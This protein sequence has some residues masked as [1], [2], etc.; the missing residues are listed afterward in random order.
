MDRDRILEMKRKKNIIKL[1][2]TVV[3]LIGL[4]IY[5][6]TLHR[7]EQII[8]YYEDTGYSG[9]ISGSTERIV[10]IRKED[11]EG[12]LYLDIR[13]N[14]GSYQLQL[15]DEQRNIIYDVTVEEGDWVRDNVPV[16][17]LSSS[18]YIIVGTV[19]AGLDNRTDIV[20]DCEM[21]SYTY[22]YYRIGKGMKKL[23]D[24]LGISDYKTR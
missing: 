12:Y 23:L 2:L 3:F 14:K 9:V 6:V 10:E 15:L 5:C 16:G 13:V 20:S 21:I 22:G 4:L 18:Q 24:L 8:S 19:S 17:K 11:V 7:N 1:I